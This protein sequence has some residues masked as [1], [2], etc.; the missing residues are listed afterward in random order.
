VV[1]RN[2]AVRPTMDCRWQ[3]GTNFFFMPFGQEG[4]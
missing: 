3:C 4:V 2:D 1:W